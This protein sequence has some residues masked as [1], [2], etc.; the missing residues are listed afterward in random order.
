MAKGS[1]TPRKDRPGWYLV[2]VYLGRHQVTG[3]SLYSAKVVKGRRAA[4]QVAAEMMAERTGLDGTATL[5]A[6]LTAWLAHIEQ[7]GRSATTLRT[8]RTIVTQ[9][10]AT[11]LGRRRLADLTA[12]HLD[13]YYSELAATGLAP[14]SVKARHRIIAAALEQAVRWQ[15]VATNVA[16][17]AQPPAVH[18]APVVAPTPQAL[19]LVLDRL[20]AGDEQDREMARAYWL[21]ALTGLRRGELAA[22]RW[23]DVIER[24]GGAELRVARAVIRSDHGLQEKATKTGKVRVVPLDPVAVT[25]L[26]DQWRHGLGLAQRAGVTLDPTGFVFPRWAPTPDGRTPLD[27]DRLSHRWQA[28]CRREGLHVRLHDLRHWHAS[29]LLDAGLPAIVVSA[30]LG[31]ATTATTLAVYG[32]LMPGADT[33]AA[34]VAGRALTGP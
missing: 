22:L 19:R 12:R 15:M 14:G 29:V 27:P 4:E 9:V 11:H 28:A 33:A 25:H 3:R 7:R 20:D 34:G 1:I 18:R 32:H 24:D 10:A 21:L 5:A 13:T 31:H 30:R 26:E 16:R 2:R 6:L 23:S 8:Y 17:R